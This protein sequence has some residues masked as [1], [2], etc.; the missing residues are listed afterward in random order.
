MNFFNKLLFLKEGIYILPTQMGN[1]F[2]GLIL[3]LI[4]LA[5]GYGNNLLLIFSLILFSLN[6]IWIIQSYLFIKKNKL[7]TIS[8]QDAF[9]EANTVFD[10]VWSEERKSFESKIFLNTN[11]GIHEIHINQDQGYK[12][13][14]VHVFDKRGHY[15]WNKLF[16]TST[17]PFGLYKCFKVQKNAGEVFVGPRIQKK[18]ILSYPNLAKKEG[19]DSD[20]ILGNDEFK[21]YAIY[22]GEGLNR[23]DW[24]IFSRR[25]EIYIKNREVSK[26][27]FY[28]RN[29]PKDYLSFDKETGLSLLMSELKFHFENG[30]HVEVILNE[31]KFSIDSNLAIYKSCKKEITLC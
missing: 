10:V 18:F 30:N 22:A 14:G 8:F 1:Y 17:L 13:K 26:G 2:N 12:S 11:H 9:A 3:L 24:K 21:D 29:W 20:K 31:K 16:F 5:G 6:F 4:L 19:N 27:R 28:K 23:I 7:D 15:R 25:N